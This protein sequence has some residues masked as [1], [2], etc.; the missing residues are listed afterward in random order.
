MVWSGRVRLAGW[1]GAVSR[2]LPWR[3]APSGLDPREGSPRVP[4][5]QLRLVLGCTSKWPL[6]CEASDVRFCAVF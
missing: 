4:Y 5:A 3:S 6:G 2:A 1:F